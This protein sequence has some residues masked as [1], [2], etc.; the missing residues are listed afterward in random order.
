MKT[1]LELNLTTTDRIENVN[2]FVATLNKLAKEKG[3]KD[4]MYIN[5]SIIGFYDGG[6]L[7]TLQVSSAQ[8]F[9]QIDLNNDNYSDPQMTSFMVL[10][11]A[12]YALLS[13]GLFDQIKTGR[14]SAHKETGIL[15]VSS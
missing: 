1:V 2:Q 4:I 5:G 7:D 12:R 8:R 9:K 3:S 14:P 6:K 11:V 15:L 13:H 10:S